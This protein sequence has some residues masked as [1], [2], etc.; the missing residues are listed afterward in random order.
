MIECSAVDRIKEWIRK[1]AET[2]TANTTSANYKMFL[3]L[4]E[5]AAA[6][7]IAEMENRE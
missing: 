6:D 4:V 7:L 3:Y 2:R 1:E 5:E